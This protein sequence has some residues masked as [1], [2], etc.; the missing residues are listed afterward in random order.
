MGLEKHLLSE[1]NDEQESAVDLALF[2]LRYHKEIDYT[3]FSSDP[4][5]IQILRRE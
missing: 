1:R 2:F 5:V 4:N 3:D